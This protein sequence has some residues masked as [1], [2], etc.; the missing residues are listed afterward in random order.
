MTA[1]C[2]LSLGFGPGL[3][4]FLL[5]SSLYARIRRSSSSL[6]TFNNR[7]VSEVKAWYSFDGRATLPVLR[8]RRSQKSAY[9][10]TTGCSWRA[11]KSPASSP[12]S[13]HRLRP[14]TLF[15]ARFPGHGFVARPSLAV[16]RLRVED[17]AKEELHFVLFRP[18]YANN[19]AVVRCVISRPINGMFGS[20]E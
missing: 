1:F 2:F 9:R 4:G 12:G 8:P 6:G 5:A 7:S 3:K 19:P 16:T 13:K 14:V 20:V 11:N 17:L 10:F 18:D 15:A